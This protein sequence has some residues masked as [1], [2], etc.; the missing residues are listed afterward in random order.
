MSYGVEYHVEA[1]AIRRTLPT[2]ARR[3]WVELERRLRH[4]PWNAGAR[5][6]GGLKDTLEAAFAAHGFATYIVQ[7]NRVMVSV[8]NLVWIG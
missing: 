8:I 5:M 7:E 6:S 2:A 3:A 1:E 4:D